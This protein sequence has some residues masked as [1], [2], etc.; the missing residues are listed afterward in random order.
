[1][2]NW[3]ITNRCKVIGIYRM[4]KIWCGPRFG[5]LQDV[6]RIGILKM[7]TYAG[8]ARCGSGC[9]PAFR[10]L[11]FKLVPKIVHKQVFLR[12]QNF[13]QV[14]QLRWLCKQ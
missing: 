14:Y 3:W 1:M 13:E 4:L 9:N 11:T 12:H 6:M 7:N 5:Y 2:E 10:M 8:F